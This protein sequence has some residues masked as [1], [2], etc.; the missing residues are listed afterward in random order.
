MVKGLSSDDV[1]DVDVEFVC[2]LVLNQVKTFNSLGLNFVEVGSI[3]ASRATHHITNYPPLVPPFSP[4]VHQCVA[5]EIPPRA[6]Q[7]VTS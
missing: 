3:K 2:A 1:T 6:H 4:L 7:T 5:A